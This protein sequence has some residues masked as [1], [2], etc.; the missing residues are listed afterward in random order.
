MT[1]LTIELEDH[2]ARIA[3]E[4]ARRANLTLS[5]WIGD[6]ISGRCRVRSAGERD[7]SGYP[8]GWFERT[9]GSL[10]GVEDFREP[11]DPPPDPVAP[12]EL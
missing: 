2:A 6:R 9:A 3:T 5:E 11:G 8:V 7:A 4:K 1:T 10:A 12:L